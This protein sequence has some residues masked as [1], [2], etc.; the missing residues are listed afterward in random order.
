MAAAQNQ[1]QPN[2]QPASNETVTREELIE[3]LNGDLRANIR[4]SSLMSFTPRC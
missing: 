4:P 3:L 1:E 2:Q